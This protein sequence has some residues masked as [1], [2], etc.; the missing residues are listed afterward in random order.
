MKITCWMLCRPWS[1]RGISLDAP[2]SCGPV[3]PVSRVAPVVGAEPVAVRVGDGSPAFD[4]QAAAITR[5]SAPSADARTRRGDGMGADATSGLSGT[6][7]PSAVR[8]CSPQ[9]RQGAPDARYRTERQAARH[10]D[11]R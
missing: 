2:V 9:L 11:P 7:Q 3:S 10:A 5:R 1:L 6:C 8:G 4:V